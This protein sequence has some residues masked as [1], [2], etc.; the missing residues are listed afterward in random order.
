MCRL[1]VPGLQVNEAVRNIDLAPVQPCDFLASQPREEAD[2]D[3]REDLR[4]ARRQQ[5]PRLDNGKDADFTGWHFD[6]ERAGHRV[7]FSRNI[8][9]ASNKGIYSGAAKDLD[10]DGDV[11]LIGENDYAGNS[12]PYIY[13]SLTGPYVAAPMLRSQCLHNETND[14]AIGFD[15]IGGLTCTL[16]TSTDL[17]EWDLLETIPGDGLPVQ[18]IHTGGAV[19]PMRFYKVV[20]TRVGH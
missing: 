11:D 9:V 2:G 19:G 5:L 1:C 15:S 17:I 8:T 10:G 7:R 20:V 14:M 18:M 12:K 16:H 13:R 4:R 6:L 3:R